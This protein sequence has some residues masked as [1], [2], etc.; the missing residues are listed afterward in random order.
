MNLIDQSIML[1]ERLINNKYL[2]ERERK[3]WLNTIKDNLE[4][5]D[6]ERHSCHMDHMELKAEN[7]KLKNG[8][9][10]D[11]VEG[12]TREFNELY[13][14]YHELKNEYEKTKYLLDLTI[15]EGMRRE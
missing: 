10:D 9:R 4:V 14:K 13:T 6:R 15:K 12:L 1:I 7:E 8:D 11:V 5:I 2:T 3:E